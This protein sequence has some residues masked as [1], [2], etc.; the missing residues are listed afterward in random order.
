[1]NPHEKKHRDVGDGGGGDV[2]VLALLRFE[3][4][5]SIRWHGES[6]TEFFARKI[7]EACFEVERKFLSKCQIESFYRNIGSWIFT[8]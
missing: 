1:M 8:N 5:R 4:K 3:G 7:T 2:V 6:S